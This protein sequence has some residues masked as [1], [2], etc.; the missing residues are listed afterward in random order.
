MIL[1]DAGQIGMAIARRL[2]YGMKIII[3]DRSL[4]NAITIADIMNKTWGNALSFQIVLPS[5]DSIL[6]LISKAHA[7]GEISMRP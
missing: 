6:R 4:A 3:G 2:G 5:R 1:T 7:Y